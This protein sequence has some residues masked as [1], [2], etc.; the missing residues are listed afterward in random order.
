MPRKATNLV[1]VVYAAARLVMLLLGMPD[2]PSSCDSCKR[3]STQ[4]WSCWSHVL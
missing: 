3:M 2:Q 4:A 1:F